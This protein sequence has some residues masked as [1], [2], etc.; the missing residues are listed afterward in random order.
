MR[1]E[2]HTHKKNKQTNNHT[3]FSYLQANQESI[4]S[5]QQRNDSIDILDAT[6][7]TKL[8]YKRVERTTNDMGDS[9]YKYASDI[10]S[11]IYKYVLF[12]SKKNSFKT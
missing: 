4:E 9:F 12:I 1:K 10:T 5:F 2:T 3:F 6:N 11:G 8:L 7:N